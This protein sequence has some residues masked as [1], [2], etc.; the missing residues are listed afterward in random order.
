MR[1]ILL[2]P[3]GSGKGTQAE[4]IEKK[5]GF[6]QISTGDL[7]RKEVEEETPVGKKAKKF[8]NQGQLVSDDIVLQILKRRIFASDCEKGYVL[9]GFPRNVEQAQKLEQIHPFHK[10]VVLYIEVSDEVVEKRLSARRVCPE[11]GTVYNVLDSKPRK[12]MR[13]DLCG[14]KLVQREDDKP[15]VIGE[16]LK[17]YHEQTEFLHTYYKRKGNY[18]KIKG[19]RDSVKVSQ[20]IFSVINKELFPIKKLEK[21][22]K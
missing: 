15:E 7:I 13:C 5:Y 14:K 19:E 22:I 17:V 8:V 6:P 3:P 11:D 20:D 4:L 21:F 2:G 9:D 1:I 12:D 16:R 10:E 18:Y